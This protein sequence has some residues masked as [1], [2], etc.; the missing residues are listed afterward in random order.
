MARVLSIE[1]GH[2]RVF[3]YI[4]S[5]SRLP[6]CTIRTFLPRLI[7]SEYDRMEVCI[8]SPDEP[9]PTN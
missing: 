3:L 9:S 4:V 7:S 8:C 1:F 5:N 2:H 6:S